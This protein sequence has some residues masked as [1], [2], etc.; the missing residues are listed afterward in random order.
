[1]CDRIVVLNFGQVIAQGAPDAIRANPEVAT[2]YLGQEV[3]AGESATD[4]G[5]HGA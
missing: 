4:G 1:V 2:A 5:D 3:G